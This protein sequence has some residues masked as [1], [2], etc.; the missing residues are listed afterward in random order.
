M[1]PTIAHVP[2]GIV[3][4][5]PPADAVIEKV[6]I[7]DWTP[8]RRRHALR[9]AHLQPRRGLVS[10]GHDWVVLCLIL[11]HPF[12]AP[13]KV[14]ALP[15]AMRLYRNRQGLTKGEKKK[16]KKEKKG[17]NKSSRSKHDPN[18]RTR[19]EL[20]LELIKLAAASFPDDRDHR[21]SRQQHLWSGNRITFR[22]AERSGI[23]DYNVIWQPS[24]LVM[25]VEAVKYS[26]EIERDMKAFFDS[27]SERS[28]RRSAALE[29]AKLGQ[30]GTDSIATVLGCDP[31]TIRHG[32][33]ELATL[34]DPRSERVR[35][36]HG[37]DPR[38]GRVR[39]PGGGRQTVPRRNP[40]LDE[41][42]LR[43]LRDSCGRPDA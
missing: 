1:T 9:P 24:L 5:Q 27:L 38:H 17:R 20:A 6:P 7:P 11:V 35:R 23:R 36:A 12:W 32:Q 3:H 8:L 34:P 19:P 16:E 41:N 42:F 18:H 31:K 29:A 39:R 10:W 13:T 22:F 28:R 14:F 25:D 15:I 30:G 4:G 26:T 2:T 21:V 37:S 33:H 43:V 40:Q